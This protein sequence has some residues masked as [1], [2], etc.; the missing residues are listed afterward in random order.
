MVHGAARC[1]RDLLVAT[2]ANAANLI[3]TASYRKVPKTIAVTVSPRE[4]HGLLYLRA[5]VD[6]AVNS[7]AN[8]RL[9]KVA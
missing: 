9:F 4:S 6:Q 8:S 3:D 2:D 1:L 5:A 7:K